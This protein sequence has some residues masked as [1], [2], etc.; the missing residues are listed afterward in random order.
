MVQGE[1]N[2]EAGF[3]IALFRLEKSFS[4]IV[5][6]HGHPLH[7]TD[8]LSSTLGSTG[9]WALRIRQ[10]MWSGTHSERTHGSYSPTLRSLKIVQQGRKTLPLRR[11]TAM[12]ALLGSFSLYWALCIISGSCLSSHLLLSSRAIRR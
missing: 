12:L 11:L 4:F 7:L 10:D 6:S 5:S 9:R 2:I 8:G 3:T 1:L